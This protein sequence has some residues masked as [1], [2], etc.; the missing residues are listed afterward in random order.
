[1]LFSKLFFTI[2]LFLTILSSAYGAKPSV[3]EYDCAY[4]SKDDIPISINQI[5][6]PQTGGSVGYIELYT[7]TDNV[8][9]S[10]W[11]MCYATS[12]DSECINIGDGDGTVYYNGNNVGNDSSTI[13]N[14]NSFVVYPET[15]FPINSGN[16]E[17]SFGQSNGEVLLI[18]ADGK[19]VH[20][21][22]YYNN[23]PKPEYSTDSQCTTT[24]PDSSANDDGICATPD[25]TI[26]TSASQDDW[27]KDCDNTMGTPNDGTTFSNLT[28]NIST[29]SE[30]T[31]GSTFAADINI[32][33]SG[34][35]DTNESM[36][37]TFPFG[38]NDGI[39]VNSDYT[40]FTQNSRDWNCTTNSTNITCTDG[41]FQNGD[42][43]DFSIKFD[44]STNAQIKTVS[45]A[46][47]ADGG[48][49][50]AN[51]SISFEIKPLKTV[52]EYR[53]DEC[54]WDGT[55]GEVKDSS[56]N[57]LNGT[58]K[59]DNTDNRVASL[60][61]GKIN[62][63]AY[64][65]GQGYNDDPY[66]T[67]YP[68]KY[69]VKVQDNDILSPLS[70]TKEMSITGWFKTDSGGTILSKSGND[71]EYRIWLENGNLKFSFYNKNNAETTHTV[72]SNVS[73]GSWHFFAVTIKREIVETTICIPF[74]PFCNTS[75]E[76]NLEFNF[77]FDSQQPITATKNDFENVNTSADFYIGAM[78]W[79]EASF[80]SSNDITN[81]FD[82]YVDEIKI[83]DKVLSATDIES[84][85]NNEN[86]GKNYD[87]SA[88]TAV[89]C[90]NEDDTGNT[91]SHTFDAWDTFRDIN[92]R[93]I[94]TKIAAQNFNL[95]IASLDESGTN[96]QDFNG[97]VCTC[98]NSDNSIC[99]KNYFSDDN[100]SADTSQGNP[101]FNIVNAIKS[102]DVN[103]SWKKDVNENCPLINEDNS[104]IAS[105]RFAI[106]PNKFSL[107]I[108]STNFYAAE[109]FVI[110]F[111][112]LDDSNNSTNN[113]NEDLN[114]TFIVESNTTK[115]ECNIGTFSLDDFTFSNGIKNNVNAKYSNLGELNILI[116]EKDNCTDKFASQDC[117]D[118]DV[119]GSWQ[120]NND[121]SIEPFTKTLTLKPYEMNVTVADMN[122]STGQ[123]WLYMADV[124]D[125]NLT[126]SATV[127]AYNKDGILLLDFNSTCSA[128]D[129]TLDFDLD[130]TGSSSLDMNYTVTNGILSSTGSTLGDINKTITIDASEFISGEASAGYALNVDRNF[131]N[132]IEPFKI[133]NMDITVVTTTASKDVNGANDNG[134]FDFYFGRVSVDDIKTSKSSVEHFIEFEVYDPSNTLGFQQN[135]LN[136][137]KNE[138][139]NN[140]KFGDITDSDFDSSP[141]GVTATVSGF[142]NGTL[143]FTLNGSTSVTMHVDVDEWLWYVPFNC[144]STCK[145]KSFDD[146][147][148]CSNHPCFNFTYKTTNTPAGVNTGD[149]K[150]SDY[151]TPSRGNYERTGVK[152]F[153]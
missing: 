78:N 96:Y 138:N 109:D 131:S 62:N 56:G 34:P 41:I 57:N 99:F 50:N 147:G 91:I 84:V 129:I 24:Y 106:R 112:A 134:S 30:V 150:G 103:I 143:P 72:S 76:H 97:T 69:Y 64:F 87:G 2:F 45:G 93:N 59:G 149:F 135:S 136:W 152:A 54:E 125:M 17:N 42:S 82:G 13:L 4:N 14:A 28:L 141:S 110:N 118:K 71:R 124:D 90:D 74:M 39:S 102:A 53:F 111:S 6:N 1:M 127:G 145:Y 92:D 73:D 122:S 65:R 55:S 114:S 32:S 133:E 126:L 23:N 44:V 79:K 52:A 113:Y 100:Q 33:N 105:D 22:T 142:S 58:A 95:S 108:P 104:T 25:G 121:I 70:T 46:V 132:P 31:A 18:R 94:S 83:F 146:G 137:S 63:A 68:A 98:I 123:S 38:S 10:G 47:N 19:A 61:S 115:L 107:S 148:S 60:E 7:K 130:T 40:S 116:K 153:R 27:D 119:I 49:G 9:L 37:L 117:N 75:E 3:T 67:W 5:Y 15:L 139:H 86:S 12:N 89:I 11:T 16:P 120:V 80:W 20:Y 128:E 36:I 8:S 85:Y 140:V 81:F 151:N 43:E 51:K 21:T 26:N 88:R 29:P 144:G 35:D 66:N 77:Y 48:N 101:S